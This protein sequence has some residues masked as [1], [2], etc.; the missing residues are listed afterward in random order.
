MLTSARE[1][2]GCELFFIVFLKRG[3]K[4]RDD[5][6]RG[7]RLDVCTGS[8]VCGPRRRRRLFSTCNHICKLQIIST[9]V[10]GLDVVH[11]SPGGAPCTKDE[12]VASSDIIT[13]DGNQ[14][15]IRNAAMD[16]A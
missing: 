8:L 14:W 13:N 2:R 7:E 3:T 16:L 10:E 12:T 11:T 9:V 4:L 15:E 1:L 6:G 5:A